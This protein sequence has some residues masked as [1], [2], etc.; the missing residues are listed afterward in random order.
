MLMVN[1]TGI[2]K[3]QA[4]SLVILVILC[5]LRDAVTLTANFPELLLVTG[6]SIANFPK[7]LSVTGCNTCPRVCILPSYPPGSPIKP[8]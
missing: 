2:R 8:L 1:G 6:C 7:L 3:C 4:L 5:D